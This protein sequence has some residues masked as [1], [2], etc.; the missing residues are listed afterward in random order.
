MSA[1]KKQGGS[2]FVP[3]TLV[4]GKYRLIKPLGEGAMGVVWSAV[5]EVTSGEVALKLIWKPEPEYRVRLLR[6]AKACGT[7]RHKNVIQI[8]DVGQT[9]GGDP[10]LVMELL[11]GETLADLLARKRRLPPP[12]AA[13]IG[14]DVA[15]ALAAAH[16]KGIVHRDLKPANIFL[17]NEPGEDQ[18]VVKVLDFGVAK[19][20]A[21]NDG[22]RTATGSA[23]G[24]PMY[25]SPEQAS[26]ANDIDERADLWSLGVVLFE[27]LTGDR[28]FR[29][30]LAE[31]LHQILAGEVPTV[32]RRVRRIDPALD[33]IVAGCLVRRR[34][35][36]LGPAAEIARL[37][38]E[39]AAPGGR[40]PLPSLMEEALSDRIPSGAASTS[41]SA[42]FSP[43]T[44]SG[45][46]AMSSPGFGAP[47]PRPSSSGHGPPG[48]ERISGQT[49]AVSGLGSAHPAMDLFQTGAPAPTQPLSPSMLREA[50][51]RGIGPAQPRFAGAAAGPADDDAATHR[52]DPRMLAPRQPDT[53][54]PPPPGGIG[55]T[56]TVRIDPAVVEEAIQARGNVAPPSGGTTSSTAPMLAAPAVAPTVSPAG[57]G[58]G[59]KGIVVALVVMVSATVLA[60]VVFFVFRSS[61]SAA[62]TGDSGAAVLPAPP[63]SAS[64]EPTAQPTAAPSSVPPAGSTTEAPTSS[65]PPPE[66]P[67]ADPTA[68][69]VSTPAKP[70]TTPVKPSAPKATATAPPKKTICEG[71]FKSI[72]EKRKKEYAPP[73]P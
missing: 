41:G 58:S 35:E 44:G 73:T 24:S 48:F 25:M 56:G 39:H 68:S 23:V 51:A 59:R 29:G 28:P 50:Q 47:E 32:A 9:D 8:H 57:S 49:P 15:R 54:P 30:D 4:A 12:E 52:L 11:T 5:N 26:K 21:A 65:A 62:P 16:A 63:A 43:R 1:S 53:A 10:F 42:P 66:A 13:A 14:R 37:L 55:P 46:S 61:T 2:A 27:M 60:A 31:V 20:L 19:N 70:T 71:P 36:R 40:E 18:A 45:P 22:L 64:A 17:H 33:A 7:V 38:D 3:G 34:E 67:P 72:C 6:E 69:A